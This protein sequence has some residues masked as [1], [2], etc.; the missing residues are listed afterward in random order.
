MCIT[1]IYVMSCV[2]EA[3]WP[4]SYPVC[5]TKKLTLYI[6][7]K[8][9]TQIFIPSM[10]IGT[11]DFYHFILLSLT[12][13]VAGV[14]RPGQSKACWLHFLPHFSSD[15]NDIKCGDEAVQAENPEIAF[16]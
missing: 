1:Q 4:A 15:E 8:L 11:V 2:C 5:A 14:I 10:R 9:W 12:L 3:G 6:T 7:R 13:T 16:G